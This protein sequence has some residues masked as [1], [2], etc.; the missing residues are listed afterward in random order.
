MLNI[1]YVSDL[2]IEDFP[3]GTSF[4]Q[5]VT[6]VSPIL[7]IA[8]DICSAWKPI[9]KHFLDWTSRN[10]HTVIL[11]AG[12][13]EYHSD[14]A[15]LHT[16][17]ETDTKIRALCKSNVIYL[18]NA[19]SY[20][21][22]GT[23]IRFVGAT[24]WSQIDPALYDYV[25]ANK[26]DFKKCLLTPTES[27]RI[28]KEHTELLET[29]IRPSSPKETLIVVTHYLPSLELLEN[30]YKGEKLHTCYASTDDWLLQPNISAWICGHSHRAT[31]WR[32]PSGVHVY[33]NA[34]G[35]NREKELLRKIDAFNPIASIP[36]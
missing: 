34:R 10:W 9:Y 21:I 31:T 8:G 11:I 13:H 29:A 15:K 16:I 33:M 4:Y 35:Y 18:Q 27:S 19:A 7:I 32:S 24:L 5:F 3:I 30:E 36:V 12:N 17:E 25:I 1:Q 6:P 28:H 2:H 22:P 23:S 20:T 26:N 14:Q